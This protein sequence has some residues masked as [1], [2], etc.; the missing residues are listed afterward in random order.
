MTTRALLKST[1]ASDVDAEDG[2]LDTA[3]DS[4]IDTS[5]A[6]YQ[7][8][9]FYFNEIRDVSFPTVADQEAYDAADAAAI[10]YAV[11]IDMAHVTVSGQ[12]RPMTRRDFLELEPLYDDDAMTGEPYSWSYYDQKVWLYPIPQDVY[13]VR[14]LGLF[15]VDGPATDDE[16]GNPWMT[17]A[18]ELLRYSARKYL[19]AN[20]K[21][22]PGMAAAAAQLEAEALADLRAQTGRRL[23]TGFIRATK[24]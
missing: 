15:K 3:I 5:I 12:R 21:M 20:K 14:L 18:F 23:G 11:K 19:A 13:T 24:F 2:Y 16:T 6:R 4:A 10:P 8:F 1:I 9:R 22:N 7:G 17:E